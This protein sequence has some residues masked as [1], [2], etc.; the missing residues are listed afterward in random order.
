[1]RTA[2]GYLVPATLFAVPLLLALVGPFFASGDT[3]KD[4]PFGAERLVRNRLRGARCVERGAAGWAV[5]HPRRRRRHV[6][7]YLSPYR[8]A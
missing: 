7:T 5:P 2:R 6:C 3:T 4:V 8:S 1:M